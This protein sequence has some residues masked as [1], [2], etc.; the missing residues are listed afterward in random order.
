MKTE[1][2][3]FLTFANHTSENS[4]SVPFFGYVRKN[5]PFLIIF[6]YI[7]EKFPIIMCVNYKSFPKPQKFGDIW[8]CIPQMYV[9]SVL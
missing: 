9:F 4:P 8:N 2:K 6:N 3:E 1:C 7:I 5:Q